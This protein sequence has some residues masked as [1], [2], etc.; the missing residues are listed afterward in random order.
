MYNYSVEMQINEKRF[1]KFNVLQT[2]WLQNLL[3]PQAVLLIGL[4]SAFR[5]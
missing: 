1:L 2:S 4:R 3:I 5:V